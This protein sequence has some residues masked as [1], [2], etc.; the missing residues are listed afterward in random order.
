VAAIA[1]GTQRRLVDI[2]T[3]MAIPASLF[4]QMK[5]LAGM[6]TPAGSYGMHAFQGKLCEFMIEGHDFTPVCTLVAGRTV[7]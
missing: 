6:A 1:L 7:F 3:T 4:R 5:F 2:L